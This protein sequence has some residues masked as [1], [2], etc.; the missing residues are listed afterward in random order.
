MGA[1]FSRPFE[2]SSS[3]SEI[4]EIHITARATESVGFSSGE[5]AAREHAPLFASVCAWHR[6]ASAIGAAI[7]TRRRRHLRAAYSASVTEEAR[8]LFEN[9]PGTAWRAALTQDAPPGP[10][11]SHAHRRQTRPRSFSPCRAPGRGGGGQ[12][13]TLAGTT[14]ALAAV[15]DHRACAQ[16]LGSRPGASSA[17][18]TATGRGG[19]PAP[20]PGPRAA[21]PKKGHGG[22]SRGRLRAA[23]AA[24]DH[25][26][27]GGRST[28]APCA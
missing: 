24:L 1:S 20:C 2:N 23:E 6:I 26:R 15:A 27:M 25:V 10:S 12:Y 5:C 9:R 22:E 8:R 21:H 13:H 16:R 18:D 4:R 19:S 17:P 14:R 11:P 28:C 3:F 7:G